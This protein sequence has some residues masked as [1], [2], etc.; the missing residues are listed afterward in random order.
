[1]LLVGLGAIFR[2]FK[3]L[4]TDFLAEVGPTMNSDRCFIDL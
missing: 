4:R 1:M 3:F 2:H